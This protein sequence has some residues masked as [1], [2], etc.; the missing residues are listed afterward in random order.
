MPRLGS[1][2][3]PVAPAPTGFATGLPIGWN[4][5]TGPASGQCFN[6]TIATPSNNFTQ[7]SFSSQNTASS[8]AAQIK[9]SAEVNLAFDLFNASDSF[10]FSDQWQSSTHSSNQYYN[11]FS[12]YTLNSTV[13]QTD[14]LTSQGEAHVTDGTF[15]V[16]C[17]NEYLAVVPVG[18]FATFSVNYGSSSESTALEITNKSC[19]TRRAGSLMKAPRGGQRRGKGPEGPANLLLSLLRRENVAIATPPLQRPSN[20]AMYLGA[21][22]RMQAVVH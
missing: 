10:S 16:L 5:S 2:R 1:R 4:S 14:P 15:A 3:R 12:L 18:L 19:T 22:G 13:S 11:M 21:L 20:P 8:T 17:G 6:Y 9:V 7:A